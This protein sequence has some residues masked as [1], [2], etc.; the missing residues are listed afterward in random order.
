[1]SQVR[2]TRRVRS[3]LSSVAN[4]TGDWFYYTYLIDQEVP[5]MDNGILRDTFLGIC[6]AST[7][8]SLLSI[9]VMGFGFHK[10]LNCKKAFGISANNWVNLLELTL[11]DIPQLVVTSLVSYHMRG[12]L[13]SQAVFNLTTSSINFT[14][15]ALDIADD[16]MDEREEKEQE[17]E[18]GGGGGGGSE[19]MVY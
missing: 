16:F 8:F 3:V 4:V 10:I 13:S 9:L 11:E 15:D 7:V 14:L 12:P 2:W 19:A 5:N 1:M 6:F 17:N 18:G